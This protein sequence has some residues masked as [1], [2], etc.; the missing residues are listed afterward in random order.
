ME[1]GRKGLPVAAFLKELG[2][3]STREQVCFDFNVKKCVSAHIL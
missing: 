3:K 2:Q 1:L